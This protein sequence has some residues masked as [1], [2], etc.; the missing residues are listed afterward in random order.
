MTLPTSVSV[1]EARDELR[2]SAADLADFPRSI[3]SVQGWAGRKWRRREDMRL[4]EMLLD[5]KPEAQ[6][7]KGMT[8]EHLVEEMEDSWTKHCGDRTDLSAS[9]CADQI[10]EWISQIDGQIVIEYSVTTLNSLRLTGDQLLDRIGK[11][12]GVVGLHRSRW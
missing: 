12:P 3:P 10:L 1:S 2:S 5:L 6:W 4:T 7:R 8:K 9:Q 11:V